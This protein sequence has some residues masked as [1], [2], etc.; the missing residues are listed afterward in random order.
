LTEVDYKVEEPHEFE[1]HKEKR[2]SHRLNKNPKTDETRL[3]YGHQRRQSP[4]SEMLSLYVET[5]SQSAP[6]TSDSIVTLPLPS[7]RKSS[8]R[9]DR[10]SSRDKRSDPPPCAQ[11]EAGYVARFL[12]SQ[13]SFYFRRARTY[14]R[15]FIWRLLDNNQILEIRCIDLARSELELSEAYL[16]VRLEVPDL[17]IPG[18]IALSDAEDREDELHAFFIS[19]KKELYT[20]TIPLDF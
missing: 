15:S 19:S 13:G 8:I 17:I 5:A 2:L 12:A 16:T 6:S 4:P 14:P 1:A 9:P 18:S 3:R 11:D 10:F 20:A 7:S